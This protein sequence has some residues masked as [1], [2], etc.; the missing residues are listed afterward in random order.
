MSLTGAVNEVSQSALH[1]RRAP[2]VAGAMKGSVLLVDDELA[3]L[4]AYTRVLTREGYQVKTA[5]DGL[6]ARALLEHESFDV[7]LSDVCM[8]G[9]DGL[10]LL[11]TVRKIDADVPVILATGAPSTQDA[12]EAVEFGALLYLI[13]PFE[14]KTL[15]QVVDHALRLHQFAKLKRDAITHL[16][17]PSAH[18]GVSSG[19]ESRFD[20][21]LSSLWMAFQPIVHWRTRRVVGFEALARCND[22]RLTQPPDLVDAAE[23]LDR[24]ND[25][26]R[27]IRDQ[28]AASLPAAPPDAQIFVNLH[29]RDLMDNSLFS[30]ASPLSRFAH[31]VTLEITERAPLDTMRDVSGRVATLRAMGFRIAVDDMG[32]G[33]AGLTAFAQIKPEVVKLDMSL[34]RGLDKEPVKRKLISAMTSL[35]KEMGMMVIA[36]GIET[37]AERDALDEL[38]CEF[39]QGYLFARPGRGFPSVSW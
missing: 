33:Y 27:A 36:E 5:T 22:P 9:M 18:V 39:M 13:K 21:A 29:A 16:G 11:R 19:L 4:R 23:R 38:G 17:V 24:L 1:T 31:R 37:A 25:L 3:I 30:P 12:G 10:N 26:G 15:L 8:P 7:I 20:E 14:F 32:A 34:I 2:L 6:Q 35:C 28:V